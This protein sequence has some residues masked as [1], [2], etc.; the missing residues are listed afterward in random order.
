MLTTIIHDLPLGITLI[1][2]VGDLEKFHSRPLETAPDTN[3]KVTEHLLD[4][5]Q[6]L[7]ALWRALKDT[8]DDVTY[9]VHAPELDEDPDNDDL[10]LSV[11]GVSRWH[12][13]R[14]RKPLWADAPTESRKRGL[15]PVRLL[16]PS[17]D[18]VDGWVNAAYP[19]PEID[20]AASAEEQIQAL[21][22]EREITAQRAY[23][24]EKVIGPLRERVR[25][26]NLPY[27]R[28]P[29]STHKEV[30]LRVFIN[31]NTN[32]KPLRAYDIVV[33]ELENATGR[34]LRSMIEDLSS[35]QPALERYFSDIGD[36]VLQVSALMQGKQ[37]NQRG[38]FE[39]DYPKF[40]QDWSLMADG[41]RRLVELLITEG[42]FDATRL[43]AGPPLPVA[44][45]LLARSDETGDGRS[46]VDQLARRYLWSAFFTTRYVGAAATRAAADYGP[47]RAALDGTGDLANVPVF[48]REQYPLPTHRELLVAGW[49]KKADRLARAVLAASTYFGA[50]DFADDTRLSPDNV[51][52]RE[53]HHLFPDA[54]LKASGIDSYL[55]LNCALITWK[56]NRMIGRL[57]P[58]EYMEARTELAPDPRD[59]QDRLDTHLVPYAVLASAGPYPAEATGAEL[60]AL[61]RPDFEAFL[62]ARA[63]LIAVLASQLVEGRRPHVRDVLVA[64]LGEGAE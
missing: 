53:Y 17:D 16:D 26:Y 45:A 55:A 38:Y 46:R 9:F 22:A 37:P 24:K 21:H 32:A 52:K 27:L 6:R 30:A 35:T 47:L 48:D 64:A 25:H 2:D 41:L 12:D 18:D 23:I 5:Q 63:R 3:A 56:T 13:S 42:I 54:L 20:D 29:A 19:A 50:R 49:P 7:T 31:M 1:L 44:A 60:A 11:R 4:G 59:V 57:D 34:R 33:A 36:A 43:P 58:I 14:G 8:N 10:G 39:M 15:I 28:L 51:G 40:V 61:V 62:N